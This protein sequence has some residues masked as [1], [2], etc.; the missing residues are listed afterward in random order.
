M[1]APNLKKNTFFTLVMMFFVQIIFFLFFIRLKLYFYIFIYLPKLQQNTPCKYPL[2]TL[3]GRTEKIPWWDIRSRIRGHL[4]DNFEIFFSVHCIFQYFT[5]YRK[6]TITM[7]SSYVILRTNLLYLFFVD[8]YSNVLGPF[9]C[10]Q[11]DFSI[12]LEYLIAL[13]NN[14]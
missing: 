7:N 6:I 3:P 2:L 1:Q 11:R 12:S 13:L 9:G 10:C 4:G 5:K 8:Y 14:S